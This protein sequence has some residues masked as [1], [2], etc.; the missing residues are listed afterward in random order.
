[1]TKP[2]PQRQ[3]DAIWNALSAPAFMN[4]QALLQVDSYGGHVNAVP[5][6]DTAVAQR[7]SILKL[8]YQ[9]YWTDPNQD[10]QNLNW[11]RSF[12]QAVY[13]DTGGVPVANGDVTDGCFVNYC[14]TDL[15]DWPTLYYKD[16]YARLVAI[17]K[18]WD[19]LNIFN[20]AQS[21]GSA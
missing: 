12:Y 17:K 11:I 18:A 16:G 2:F 6:G 5:A 13:A 9:I 21:I 14:D 20:H 4:A 1:M 19:P 15:V 7:S 8:Q 3:I 10:D